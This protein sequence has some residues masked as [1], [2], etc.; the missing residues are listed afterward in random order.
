MPITYFPTA[1]EHARKAA[2]LSY[3]G[4]AETSQSTP[5]Y[6]L[7][8]CRGQATPERDMV[9][10]LCIGLSLSAHQTNTYLALSGHL[11]F[12]DSQRDSFL[13]TAIHHRLPVLTI[14][15]LLRAAGLPGLLE[16]SR[17]PSNRAGWGAPAAPLSTSPTPP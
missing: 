4:W 11:P 2:G 6:L 13:R 8:I 12:T 10:R 16:S 3:A 17:R 5:S 15:E 14:H 1:I 9:I 7:R